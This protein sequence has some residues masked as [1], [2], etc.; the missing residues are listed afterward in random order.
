[1]A[2]NDAY[3]RAGIKPDDV[4]VAATHDCF[5]ISEIIE[6]EDFGWCEKGEGGSFIEAGQADVG[7]KVPVNPDGGLLSCGHPFGA[8]G[9]RQAQEMIQLWYPDD[10]HLFS[11]GVPDYN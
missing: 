9:V 10:I 1:M 3:R 2:A 11:N 6:Y 8:T 4:D 5:T 7:G